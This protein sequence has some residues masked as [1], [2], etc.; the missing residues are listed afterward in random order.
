VQR[1]AEQL[2]LIEGA[3]KRE[4]VRLS[5]LVEAA[6]EPTG[7]VDINSPAIR[8]RPGMCP[9]EIEHVFVAGTVE[10]GAAAAVFPPPSWVDDAELR[11][12]RLPLLR[13]RRDLPLGRLGALARVEEPLGDLASRGGDAL[14]PST[15]F[16]QHVKTP[17]EDGLQ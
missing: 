2:E 13:M 5:V 11:L 8:L 15:K 1:P 17:R 10:R 7:V 6:S 14:G 16:K 3:L 4:Q 9:A 12:N